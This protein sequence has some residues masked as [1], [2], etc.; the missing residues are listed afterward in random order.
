MQ[1]FLNARDP[2]YNMAFSTLSNEVRKYRTRVC[3]NH[4]TGPE[5][6]SGGFSAGGRAAGGGH[7]SMVRPPDSEPS[8]DGAAATALHADVHVHSLFSPS[9]L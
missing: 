5:D 7:L 8:V 4:T 6:Q 3:R 2:L 9:L 1:R